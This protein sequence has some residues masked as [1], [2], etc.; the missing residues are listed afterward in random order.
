MDKELL[1]LE[2]EQF[3]EANQSIMPPSDIVAYN[4][5]RS[6]SDI[7]RMYIKSQLDIKPD[8]QR[9]EVWSD[10]A[11]TRFVD[12]VM[13]GLPIPSMCISLDI[14]TQKRLVIDGLQRISTIIHFLNKKEIE[15]WKMKKCDDVYE[16][17]SGKKVSEVLENNPELYDR[18]E[19][20]TIPITV[21]RCDYSNSLHM[22]YLFNIFK[23]LNSGGVKLNNQEI[24]NCIYQ[25]NFNNYIKDIAK[26]EPWKKLRNDADNTRHKEDELILRFYAMYEKY[27][28]YTGNMTSFLNKYMS[29]NQTL[30][31]IQID[32]FNQIMTDTLSIAEKVEGLQSEGINVL[33]SV[34]VGIAKNI[35][36]LIE[37]D[38]ERITFLFKQLMSQP[39]YFE[40][41]LQDGLSAKNKVIG[42][43][44]KSIKIFGSDE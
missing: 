41:N 33:V 32:R 14:K 3:E 43:L 29:L 10:Q 22:E 25:G 21:I 6:C 34:L 18:F 42:R 36:K 35:D 24:R 13:K 19:N 40:E 20:A 11:K 15:D 27:E 9:N 8:F 31:T 1:K 4:E 5:L 7:Y 30:T 38:K 37:V 23:R 28:D 17:I 2:E 44:D 16:A 39:E 12:S 26:S